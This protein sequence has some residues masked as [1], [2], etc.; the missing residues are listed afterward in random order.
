MIIALD[1][2]D[3]QQMLLTKLV[4]NSSATLIQQRIEDFRL[5]I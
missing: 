4:G 5:R 1:D 2:E 3:M